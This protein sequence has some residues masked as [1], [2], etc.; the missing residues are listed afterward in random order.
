MLLACA[1]PWHLRQPGALDFFVRF[2]TTHESG[3]SVLPPELSVA[4]EH[5]PASLLDADAQGVERYLPLCR[6]RIP[7][8]QA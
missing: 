3:G 7:H 5:H 2:A 6:L 4:G 1:R 8:T